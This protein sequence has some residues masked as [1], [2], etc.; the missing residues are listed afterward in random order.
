MQEL[1][2]LYFA[3]SIMHPAVGLMAIQIIPVQLLLPI[4]RPEHMFL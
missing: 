2:M 4:Y 1:R 3:T